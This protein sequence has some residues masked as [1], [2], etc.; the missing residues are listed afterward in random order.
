M[1][2]TLWQCLCK[3]GGM[4]SELEGQAVRV[5]PL[6]GPLLDAWDSLP[7]DEL[8]AL[9]EAVP[10]FCKKMNELSAAVEGDGWDD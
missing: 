8:F 2:T 7:N 6:I 1:R 9:K 3:G 4:K 10:I 5:M